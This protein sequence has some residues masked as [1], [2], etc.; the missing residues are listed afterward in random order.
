MKDRS[1]G[2]LFVLFLLTLLVSAQSP[3]PGNPAR[4]FTGE[5]TDSICA[6]SGSHTAMMG[7]DPSMGDDKDTCTKQCARLVGKYVLYDP[8][9]KEVFS[10]DNQ[11][12]GRLVCRSRG[13]DHRFTGRQEHSG[14]YR[15]SPDLRKRCL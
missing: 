4:T 2:V 13:S 6:P 15:R 3:N 8:S 5:I 11:T 7:K 14:R 12:G 9:T 1:M 10:L